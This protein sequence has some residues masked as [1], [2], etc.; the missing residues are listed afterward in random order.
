M[1]NV[2]PLSYREQGTRSLYTG[3]AWGSYPLHT[4]ERSWI[5]VRLIV[6]VKRLPLKNKAGYGCVDRHMTRDQHGFNPV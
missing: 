6:I 1:I 2:I 5:I 4:E 3:Q